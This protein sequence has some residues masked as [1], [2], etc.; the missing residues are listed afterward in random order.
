MR[1]G[2]KENEKILMLL[3]QTVARWCNIKSLD[4]C[5]G[6]SQVAVQQWPVSSSISEEAGSLKK[7]KT[8]C[9]AVREGEYENTLKYISHFENTLKSF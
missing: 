8:D 5:I 9:S 3:G 2:L 1:E 4:F 7:E 6:V